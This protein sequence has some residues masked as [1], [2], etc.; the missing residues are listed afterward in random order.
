MEEARRITQRKRIKEYLEKGHSLTSRDS[1]NLF[2]CYRLSAVIYVLKHDYGMNI[3]TKMI[4]GKDGVTFGRY[5]LVKSNTI[6]QK[7]SEIING[8]INKI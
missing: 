1:V 4:K 2:N 6:E 3:E 5:K 8:W 7:N